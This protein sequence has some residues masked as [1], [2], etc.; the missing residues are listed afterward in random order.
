MNEANRSAEDWVLE[1]LAFGK[2]AD[3]AAAFPDE[4]DRVLSAGFLAAL[5]FGLV[6]GSAIIF[7]GLMDTLCSIQ[8][9]IFAAMDTAALEAFVIC[10]VC[11]TL[12]PVTI[13]YLWRDRAYLL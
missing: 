9:G 8:R 5:L 6:G 7:L 2:T 10:A 11:L 12:G 1:R 4:K 3:L 13:I